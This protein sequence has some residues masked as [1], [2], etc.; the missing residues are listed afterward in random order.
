M[1]TLQM[2]SLASAAVGL[3]MLSSI[4]AN[5]V[6]FQTRATILTTNGNSSI[7]DM[8][9]SYGLVCTGYL[10][11]ASIVCPTVF[12]SPAAAAAGLAS[13]L[14]CLNTAVTLGEVQVVASVS[15]CAE[16]NPLI[17]RI[18]NGQQ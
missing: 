2:I 15:S 7:P 14:Q 13:L 8:M 9:T 11:P 18:V 17:P 5:A 4:P 6:G 1:K 3:L 16:G 12:S 10:S